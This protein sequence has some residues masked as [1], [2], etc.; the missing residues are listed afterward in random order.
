M[1]IKSLVKKSE[2]QRIYGDGV[3]RVGRLLVVYL[4]S[5]KENRQSVVASKKVGNAVC[6][7]RAKRLLREALRSSALGNEIKT[8][9]I[10]SRFFPVAGED[11]T[12]RNDKSGLWIVLVA[13]HKILG[14]SSREVQQELDDL[15]N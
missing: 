15:L 8:E 14:A 4:L 5:E 11:E 12:A 10:W 3:K 2:F 1:T 13:R 7:N 6:R 9:E